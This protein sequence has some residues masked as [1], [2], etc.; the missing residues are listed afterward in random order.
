MWRFDSLIRPP[1]HAPVTAFD[2]AQT[3]INARMVADAPSA[4][5]VLRELL[6]RCGSD[7][8][9]LVAH[10]AHVERRILSAYRADAGSLAASGLLDTLRLAKLVFPNL[11]SYGLANVADHLEVRWPSRAHRALAD[12]L[13][14][15]EVLKK[16]VAII[17][18][19]D[20]FQSG[21]QRCIIT[22]RI[23]PVQESLF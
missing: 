14:T 8:P 11:G 4:P 1:E 18:R 15:A 19:S 21:W 7:R 12:A 9:L 20:R 10:N 17:D 2:T 5:K 16:L 13:V 6:R 22:E 23:E 3:G